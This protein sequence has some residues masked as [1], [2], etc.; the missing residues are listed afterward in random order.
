MHFFRYKNDGEMRVG[1]KMWTVNYRKLMSFPV[2]FEAK[3]NKGAAKMKY[4][5]AAF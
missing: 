3:E 2:R 4:Y 5:K 1:R